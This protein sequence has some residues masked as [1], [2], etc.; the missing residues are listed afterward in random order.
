MP[1]KVNKLDLPNY[2]RKIKSPFMIYENFES[3]LV[4]ENN[5]KK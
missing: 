2:E 3:M 5:G 1:K 4:L